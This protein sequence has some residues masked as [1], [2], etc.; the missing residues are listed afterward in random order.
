MRGGC[1]PRRRL[2]ASLTPA[3]RP[4][5]RWADPPTPRVRLNVAGHGVAGHR[6]CCGSRPRPLVHPLREMPLLVAAAVT[7]PQHELGAVRGVEPRIVQALA[8]GRVDQLPAYR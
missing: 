3:A 5:T 1:A 6:W 2:P 8:G 7:G 4:A